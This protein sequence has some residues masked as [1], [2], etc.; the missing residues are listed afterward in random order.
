MHD[1][2][3]QSAPPRRQQLQT[4][5]NVRTLNVV[6]RMR[7]VHSHQ[8]TIA[9]ALRRNIK[10]E[11]LNNTALIEQHDKYNIIECVVSR[12]WETFYNTTFVLLQQ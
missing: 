7:T 9:I 11:L 5:F 6:V 10:P 12:Y 8:S 4:M 2:R 1:D 3:Q